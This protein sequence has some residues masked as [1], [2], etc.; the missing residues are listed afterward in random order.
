MALARELWAAS[1][2]GLDFRSLVFIDETGTNTSMVR[3]HGWCEKGQR[4]LAKAPHGH[5]MA[6]TFVAGLQHD[7]IL[8]PQL[9]PCP[10]TGDIFKQWL[11][12]CLIPEMKPGSVVVMDNLPAH[13]VKGVRDCLEAAGMGLL[14]LPP[15]SPDYN[16]IENA[17]S[18]IKRWIR[19]LA[20]RSFDAICDALNTIL[21]KFR[22]REYL[23]YIKH[24]GYR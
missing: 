14:Y 7:G 21:K 12:E 8:A 19:R 3:T 1:Q 6:S 17:F 11:T 13:K 5:W 23:R 4:L 18:K 16:P 22:K 15:Y 10:M 9:I 20:P 2:S 24:A